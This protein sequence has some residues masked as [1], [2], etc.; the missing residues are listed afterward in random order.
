MTLDYSLS[1]DIVPGSMAESSKVAVVLLLE[2]C[3]EEVLWADY[4]ICAG[5][6]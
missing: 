4:M 6:L 1:S 2:L 3:L 5:V